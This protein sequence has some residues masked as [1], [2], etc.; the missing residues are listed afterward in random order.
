M[1]LVQASAVALFESDGYDSTTVEAIAEDSGVSASTIYRHFGTKER[2]VLWDERDQVVDAE[3]LKRLS[4]QPPVEAFRD[5]V[6]VALAERDDIETFLRRLKLIYAEPAIWGAAAQEDQTDRFELAKAFALTDL[7]RKVTIADEVTAA[8]CL[9]A[10]DVALDRWQQSDATT[11]L[12][13]LINE[14]VSAA[15]GESGGC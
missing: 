14:A 5:A 2:L 4:R 7:R 15:A 6:I 12:S 3:L 1:R 10:L 11:S 8:V 9:A 13:D